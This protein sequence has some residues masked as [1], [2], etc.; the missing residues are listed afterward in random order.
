MLCS[1]SPASRPRKKNNDDDDDDKDN[2]ISTLIKK[3]KKTRKKSTSG[4]LVNI[5]FHHVPD[6]PS[7]FLSCAAGIL[8][9]NIWHTGTT[10]RPTDAKRG[11]SKE[12]AHLMS[13]AL[14]NKRK[15]DTDG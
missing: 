11:S 14:T 13:P 7:R 15:N 6:Q 9:T 4:P 12:E 5:L 3:V 8:C 2:D 10:I 1:F